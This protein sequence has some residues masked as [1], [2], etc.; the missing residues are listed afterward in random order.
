MTV[1]SSNTHSLQEAFDSNIG[2]F[3]FTGLMD[4]SSGGF[5]HKGGPNWLDWPSAGFRRY[6]NSG[7][8]VDHQPDFSMDFYGILTGETV[9]V[10]PQFPHFGHSIADATTRLLASSKRKNVV[11]YVA[12]NRKI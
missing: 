3:P 2:V 5:F 9:W 1:N 12:T 4:S 7:K 8:P 11:N 6:Q 10:G